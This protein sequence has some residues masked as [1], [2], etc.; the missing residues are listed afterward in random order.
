VNA[1]EPVPPDP[2]PPRWTG[3]AFP[4]YRFIPGL[5]PHPRRDPRG[6]S[7]ALPEPRVQAIDDATW[8]S[9]ALY[10]RGVDLFNHAYW[11]E[12]HEAFEALWRGSASPASDLL[13]GLIQLAASEIKRFTPKPEAADALATKS[14]ARL[15][16]VPSRYL[17]IDVRA[18]EAEVKKR[19]AGTRA[20]QPVLELAMPPVTP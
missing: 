19:V 8:P 20:L 10:L 6:H 16:S 14:L 4:R 17:G 7:W 12:S 5:S 1:R 18:L 13:Q 15:A 9:C 2:A 11:W 3:G